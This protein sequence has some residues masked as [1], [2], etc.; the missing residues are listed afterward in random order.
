M[1]AR[2]DKPLMK[3]MQ[4]LNFVYS[5]NGADRMLGEGSEKSYEFEVKGDSTAGVEG[6]VTGL[7]GA[8]RGRY[9]LVMNV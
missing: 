1:L 8:G 9:R 5:T 7:Q 3:H 4:L 6:A 2:S